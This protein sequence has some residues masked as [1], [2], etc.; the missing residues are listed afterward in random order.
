MDLTPLP[1]V[2]RLREA[3][4]SGATR[5]DVAR[6]IDDHE[7][8]WVRH[9]WYAKSAPTPPLSEKWEEHRVSHLAQLDLELRRRPGHAASHTSAALVHQLEVS[10]SPQAN[11]DLSA[12]QRAP[13]SRREPDLS[14]HCAKIETPVEVIDG[15]LTTTLTRTVA[16]FLRVRSLPHGLA[17]LDAALRDGQVTLEAVRRELDTQ[18]RWRGRP[19]ALG[20][21]TLADPL[22]ESWAESYTFGR[23]HLLGIPMPLH[24]VDILDEHLRWLARVDGLWPEAGVAGECDG[25]AKYFLREPGDERP[26][27][28][29]VRHRLEEERR[30]QEPVEHLGLPFV[31]WTPDEVREQPEAVHGRVRHAFAASHPE[32]FRGY[33]VYQGEARRLPFSVETPSVDAEDLRYRR[34]RR[35]RR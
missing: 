3:L 21:L 17:L 6:A 26:V 25:H 7:I 19:R 23:L 35:R 33:V 18:R 10:I 28:E 31:R 29:V 24:Q 34:T 16:D 15:R 30:R 2:F 9:G 12:V 11:V 22:R 32:Q 14:V 27:E 4:A 8:S 20:V 1:D 13:V 5:A